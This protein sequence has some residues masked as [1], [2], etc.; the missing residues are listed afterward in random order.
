MYNFKKIAA[1]GLAFTMVI[2]S[3]V[4][5]FASDPAP[6]PDVTANMDDATEITG[7]GTED[8]VNK[9]VMKVT[10]PTEDRMNAIFDYR[11]DPQGLIA[12]SKNYAGTAVT[13]TAT[14]VVFLNTANGKNTISNTSDPLTITNKSS[15]PVDLGVEVKLA[16]GD[17][18]AISSTSDF[19]G[20]DAANAI[21]LGVKGTYDV[22]RALSETAVKP[23]TTLLSG[24]S[25]YTAT[26]VASDDGGAY[27]WAPIA[28][29][30][31]KDYTF[32]VT[33]AINTSLANSTWATV[34]D[35]TGAV[36]TKNPPAISFKYKLTAVKDALPVT[37]KWT[38][39]SSKNDVLQIAKSGAATGTGGFTVTED[40]DIEVT[41][42]YVNGI[43]I[44][45]DD[46]TVDAKG[47]ATVALEKIFANYYPAVV[48][49]E[50]FTWSGVDSKTKAAVKALIK[51]V[52]ATTSGPAF[53][54]EF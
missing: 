14:G 38:T 39:D 36:T 34:N 3:T 49:D 15:I 23:D 1:L 9:N 41:K 7:T 45:S 21:Y 53:Y 33:G 42:L 8:Y 37:L 5:A 54:G 18:T 46:F 47:Y 52:K 31:W 13:G 32:T 28:S 44:G 35:S 48:A 24:E 43:E 2:G 20:D 25:Q 30:K 19:S 6:D 17:I 51:S 29:P 50:D 4:T 11:L 40:G 27:T 22:E 16:G 12:K 10:L 26:W